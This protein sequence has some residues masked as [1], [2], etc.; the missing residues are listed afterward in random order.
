L[1]L[2][3]IAS[4]QGCKLSRSWFYVANLKEFVDRFADEMIVVID[5]RNE[6]TKHISLA[7]N[8]DFNFRDGD[9][10]IDTNVSN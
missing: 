2:Y 8:C 5:Y 10:Y 1:D 7:M 9:R 4:R 3:R 6:A